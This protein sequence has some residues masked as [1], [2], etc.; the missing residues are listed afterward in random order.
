MDAW[1]AEQSRQRANAWQPGRKILNYAGA[2]MPEHRC[3]IPVRARVVWGDEA[4]E[5]WLDNV[6]LGWSGDLVYVPMW[7]I[8]YVFTATW[9]HASDVRRV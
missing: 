6:A 2:R 5:Q 7:G 9:L 1:Q 4:G 8:G 3:R